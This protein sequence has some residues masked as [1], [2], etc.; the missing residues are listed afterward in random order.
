[1]R[2]ALALEAA[3]PCRFRAGAAKKRANY[4]VERDRPKLRFGFP[5]LRYGGPSPQTLGLFVQSFKT[6][7]RSGKA[8]TN[9]FA[10]VF[11]GIG[12]FTRRRAFFWSRLK[13]HSQPNARQNI[14]GF[15]QGHGLKTSVLAQVQT[16]RFGQ[17]V[18][19][20]RQFCW[21]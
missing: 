11:Y 9:V 19:S 3:A 15:V 20:V 14:L 17:V 4:S 8:K 10:D 21:L 12:L 18:V 2:I 13:K 5:P 1:M 6:W 7:L 16:H